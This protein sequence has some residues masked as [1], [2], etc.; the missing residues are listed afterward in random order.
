MCF[1][2]MKM[3]LLQPV[4]YGKDTLSL[5]RFI[6]MQMWGSLAG[7]EGGRGVLGK[8]SWGISLWGP[9]QIPNVLKAESKISMGAALATLAPF[10]NTTPA[11][12]KN[13]PSSCT[14]MPRTTATTNPALVLVMKMKGVAPSLRELSCPLGA[15][16]L[17]PL[18]VW[19]L[20][21]WWHVAG[22]R[23]FHC[24][25]KSFQR[26]HGHS[27]EGRSLKLQQRSSRGPWSQLA[28]TSTHNFS[29]FMQS[30]Q[31][32]DEL[33]GV[34]A[35]ICRRLPSGAVINMNLLQTVSCLLEHYSRLK[36]LVIQR[37][38]QLWLHDHSKVVL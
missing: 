18:S 22:I 36:L 31:W 5:Q 10:N 33:V 28:G 29:L 6:L 16:G 11:T 26:L 4:E 2:D 35:N 37:N 7:L 24:G 25:L 32:E 3:V 15:L 30:W 21:T 38:L 14:L 8:C 20:C 1:A 17:A 13:T 19:S 27:L 34:S 9:T 12:Q 23:K